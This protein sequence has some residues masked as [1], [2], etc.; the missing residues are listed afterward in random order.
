MLVDDLADQLLQAV[1]QGHQTGDGAVLVGHHG[2][3]EMVALHVAHEFGDRLV[4]GNHYRRAHERLDGSRAV[5]GP[6][7]PHQV[8]RIGDADDVLVVVVLAQHRHPAHAVLEAQ[9]K[10]GVDGD[11]GLHGHDV[12]TRD[13]DFPD[14]GVAELD[15]RLDELPLLVLDDLL[16]GRRLDEAE[17]LLL[18]DERSLF[19]PLALHDD[20]GETDEAAGDQ[21][22]RGEPHQQRRDPRRA[23]GRPVGLLHRVGLRHGL[24][25]HEEHDHVQH[26]ADCHPERPE[27]PSCDH[28]GQGCLHR[29]ADVHRQQERVDPPLRVTDEAQESLS[30]SRTGI[31]ECL[32]LRLRH[33]RESHLGDRQEDQH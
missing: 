3:V 21:A 29:L 17:E 20:V 12:G 31:S 2:H 7:R 26:H 14:H 6:H 5:P 23:E 28:T 10:R 18:T 30:A 9:V 27:Q 32:G 16:L 1:L 24:C 13:H 8:L 19:Q 11:V 22:Q 33:P 15:D 25:Q 4:L